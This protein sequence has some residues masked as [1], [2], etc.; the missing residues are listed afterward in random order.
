MLSIGQGCKLKEMLALSAFSQRLEEHAKCVAAE[1]GPDQCQDPEPIAATAGENACA[2]AKM[3][4]PS[5]RSPTAEIPKPV[6]TQI[7]DLCEE[8]QGTI[9]SLWNRQIQLFDSPPGSW[10]MTYDLLK[11]SVAFKSPRST[12]TRD[13]RRAEEPKHLLAVMNIN[14]APV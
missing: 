6:E 10:K 7:N 8:W 3:M 13:C 2:E 12:L 1:K 5:S 14:K 4:M 11:T 9:R